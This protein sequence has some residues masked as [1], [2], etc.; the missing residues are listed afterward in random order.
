MHATAEKEKLKEELKKG[1]LWI[2][3]KTYI[4]EICVI[5]EDGDPDGETWPSQGSSDSECESQLFVHSEHSE[6][7]SDDDNSRLGDEVAKDNDDS[8]D[9]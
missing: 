7:M 6:E 8:D 2:L 5:L 1:C 3:M 9:D 4:M